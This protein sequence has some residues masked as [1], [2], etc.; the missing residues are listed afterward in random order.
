MKEK[1]VVLLG[2]VTLLN[3][4]GSETVSRLIPFYVTEVL[5]VSK[6]TVGVIEGVA[7]TSKPFSP[8][9]KK[10]LIIVGFFSLANSSDAFRSSWT[11]NTDHHGLGNL[12]Y[13][14]WNRGNRSVSPPL[15]LYRHSSRL[16]A[17]LWIH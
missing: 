6:S 16:R 3:D 5:G 15:D 10:Y 9:L 11:A 7:E 1:N 2:I 13:H 14:L 17:L 4:L 8:D 12:L